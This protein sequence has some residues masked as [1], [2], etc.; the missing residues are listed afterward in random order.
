[1]IIDPIFFVLALGGGVLAA[2][3]RPTVIDLAP[4][5]VA[6]VLARRVDQEVPGIF[7]DKDGRPVVEQ[8]PAEIVKLPPCSRGVQG[9]GEVPAA[10]GGAVAAQDLARRKSAPLG[11]LAPRAAVRRIESSISHVVLAPCRGAL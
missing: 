1:M 8:E 11:P 6:K 10:L 5:V 3:T 4:V 7:F 9:E 2:D